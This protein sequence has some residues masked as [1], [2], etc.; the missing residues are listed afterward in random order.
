MGLKIDLKGWPDP[1][2]CCEWDLNPCLHRA[3]NY[4]GCKFTAALHRRTGVEPV[5]LLMKSTLGVAICK[6]IS[7]CAYFAV[8]SC[9]HLLANT[10]GTKASCQFLIRSVRS[11]LT[12]LWQLGK[13]ISPTCVGY[14][15]ITLKQQKILFL[16]F[17]TLN[18]IYLYIISDDFKLIGQC[19]RVQN[20]QFN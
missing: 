4:T 11:T 2:I 6:L 20:S 8:V 5:E 12:L 1:E 3:W 9:S 15:R 19:K 13:Q 10:R 7:Q 14:C 17:L 16:Y 18:I